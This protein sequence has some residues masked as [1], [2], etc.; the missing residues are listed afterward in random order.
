VRKTYDSYAAIPAIISGLQVNDTV[1][2]QLV[3]GTYGSF[4]PLQSSAAKGAT[5]RNEYLSGITVAQKQQRIQEIITTKVEDM[6][7]FAPAFTQML[8]GSH[9]VTIGNRSKIEKDRNLFVQLSEL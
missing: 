4:D 7:A 1:L 2:E 9:R 8:A 6:R 3:I 5:A